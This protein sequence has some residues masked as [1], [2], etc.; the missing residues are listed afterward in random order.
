MQ[1]LTVNL[2]EKHLE[3]LRKLKDL[4]IYP[5]ISHAIRTAVRNFLIVELP[6]LINLQR[7]LKPGTPPQEIYKPV[8]V[9]FSMLD[10]RN[11]LPD[12]IIDNINRNL[13][14]E[15]KLIEEER[16]QE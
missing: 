8:Q 6:L 3:A 1:I 14:R 15:L 16:M 11:G 9:S 12:D 2:P 7:A 13:A 5:S 4:G 10:M